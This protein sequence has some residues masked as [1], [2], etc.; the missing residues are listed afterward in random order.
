MSTPEADA[1]R[2]IEKCA[3]EVRR[4]SRQGGGVPPGGWL[5][6]M[7]VA[8]GAPQGV[9]AG[10]LGCKRQAWPQFEASEARGAISLSSLQRTA[11]ALDCDFVY[12]LVPRQSAA[13]RGARNDHA[14]SPGPIGAGPS[15]V[16]TV[17]LADGL[18]ANSPGVWPEPALPTELL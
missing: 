9:L 7:R 4:L 8:T 13:T 18:P 1:R 12:F 11:D 16:P 17:A 5:R 14:V 3:A 2:K 15:P 10:K 6:A